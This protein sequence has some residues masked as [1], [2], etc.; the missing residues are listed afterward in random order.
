MYIHIHIKAYLQMRAEPKVSEE[1][2]AGRS[3]TA[4]QPK[5]EVGVGVPRW[6]DFLMR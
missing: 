4:P 5:R 3:A 1:Q 2:I 6:F